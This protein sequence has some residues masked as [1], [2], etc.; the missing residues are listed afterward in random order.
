MFLIFPLFFFPIQLHIVKTAWHKKPDEEKSN[1]SSPVDSVRFGLKTPK[2][3]LLPPLLMLLF[4]LHF[5]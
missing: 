1:K 3:F 4:P 2:V 5:Y